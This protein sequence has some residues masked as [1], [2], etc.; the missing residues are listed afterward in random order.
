MLGVVIAFGRRLEIIVVSVGKIVCD[1]EDA[2]S[3][4]N[5]LLEQVRGRSRFSNSS[6]VSRDV[7]TSFSVRNMM[8]MSKNDRYHQS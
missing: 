5:I 1:A 6:L 3:T 8:H 4:L 7:S 2:S